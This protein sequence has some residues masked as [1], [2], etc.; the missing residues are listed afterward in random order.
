MTPSHPYTGFCS[1][2]PQASRRGFLQSLAGVGALGVIL[3]LS[4]VLP[5]TQFYPA[6]VS[7][8]ASGMQTEQA[9]VTAQQQRLGQVGVALMAMMRDRALI[10]TGPGQ[11][12]AKLTPAGV[13]WMRDE[14]IWPSVTPKAGA[15]LCMDWTQREPHLA[16]AVEGVSGEGVGEE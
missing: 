8:G 10:E 2:H 1:C 11:Q 3:V 6:L 15:R 14:Q 7:Q 4:R 12:E 13:R 16:G 5:R 9:L